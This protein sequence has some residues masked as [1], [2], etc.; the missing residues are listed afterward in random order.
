MALSCAFTRGPLSHVTSAAYPRERG[1][2]IT[3]L[4]YLF[5]LSWRTSEN[6]QNANFAEFYK[7]EVQLRRILILRTRVNKAGS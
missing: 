2:R 4:Q 6:A 1:G 7:S 3:Q 5:Q